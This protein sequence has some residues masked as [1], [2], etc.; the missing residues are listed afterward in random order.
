[1]GWLIVPECALYMTEM[2]NPFQYFCVFQLPDDMRRNG[3]KCDAL[4]A[5]SYPNSLFAL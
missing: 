1:M 3:C 5:S 2:T 4:A